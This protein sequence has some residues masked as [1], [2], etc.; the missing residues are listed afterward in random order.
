MFL[1]SVSM[2]LCRACVCVFPR[3]RF[4]LAFC[5]F[6]SLL[7]QQQF[8]RKS[9]H[10]SSSSSSSSRTRRVHVVVPI[11]H[12]NASVSLPTR[13]PTTT[14]PRV[15]CVPRVWRHHNGGRPGWRAA[16]HGA[17]A[18]AE[19]S[20]SARRSADLRK[21][22]ADQCALSARR[23]VCG[24]HEFRGSVCAH[25]SR[26]GGVE[27]ELGDCGRHSAGKTPNNTH[28]HIHHTH[29]QMTRT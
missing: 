21:R 15:Q 7:H 1:L 20:L 28:T 25:L 5:L 2:I 6:S 11:M 9:V 12:Q 29:T 24:V 8:N 18:G 14:H 3:L 23:H 27:S 10:A 13:K 17:L 4:K 19:A 26:V 22:P 16:G